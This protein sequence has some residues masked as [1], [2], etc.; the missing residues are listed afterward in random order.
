[1]PLVVVEE[2]ITILLVVLEDL[3]VVQEETH[4]VVVMV[5]LVLLILDIQVV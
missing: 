2:D 5:D 1:M 4:P 3:E